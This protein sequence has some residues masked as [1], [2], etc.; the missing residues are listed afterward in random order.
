MPANLPVIVRSVAVV[1]VATAL[2]LVVVG[3]ATGAVGS[4]SLRIVYRSN[5]DTKPLSFTLRCGPA[6][7]TVRLPVTAC[8][9]LAAGGRALFAPTP[10]GVA[11]SQVY[12][13]PQTA[14][15]TGTLAGHR[16]WARFT[17]RDGCEVERWNRVAFLFP[18]L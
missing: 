15:V 8:R 14:I 6:G 16:L 17:R 11:C 12:G 7:G 10:P 18:R 3:T 2:G 4:T 1:A 5:A 13:G 9:R